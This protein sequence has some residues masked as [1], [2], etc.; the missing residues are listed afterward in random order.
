MTH[1]IAYSLGLDTAN[2]QSDFGVQSSRPKLM[3]D[4]VPAP[5]LYTL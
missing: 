3:S 4:R 1:Q 2:R 5:W